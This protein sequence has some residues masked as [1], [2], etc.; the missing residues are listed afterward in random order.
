MTGSAKRRYALGGV[1]AGIHRCLVFSGR[2][3]SRPWY[4][5][6]PRLGVGPPLAVAGAGS[7]SARRPP[8][9]TP[10][11]TLPQRQPYVA[12]NRTLLMSTTH[13]TRGA[14]GIYHT[15]KGLQ[16][17]DMNLKGIR[18]RATSQRM[19][20]LSHPT[21]T[22]M[23]TVRVGGCGEWGRVGFTEWRVTVQ[24]KCSP[25]IH[26]PAVNSGVGQAGSQEP[27]KRGRGG[28]KRGL[29]C[30]EGCSPRKTH[31]LPCSSVL[32]SPCSS[33]PMQHNLIG[34]GPGI[35]GVCRARG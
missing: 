26:S 35:G 15:V 10:A 1:D 18:L 30:P 34:V 24:P 17:A 33:V 11:C 23:L 28:L 8:T 32:P 12:T 25:S 22:R 13:L 2:Q 29:L 6:C 31:P 20:T 4:L 7:A 3:P 27:P 5:R 19:G 16:E 14:E 9:P 21:P